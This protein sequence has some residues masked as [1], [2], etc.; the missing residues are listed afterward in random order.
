[1]NLFSHERGISFAF[2]D[3]DEVFPRPR[4]FWSHAGLECLFCYDTTC[5]NMDQGDDFEGAGES[6]NMCLFSRFY[7]PVSGFPSFLFWR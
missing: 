1:M 5:T 4:L 6:K 7:F 3:L 2:V